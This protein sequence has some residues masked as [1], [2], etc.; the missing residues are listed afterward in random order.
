MSSTNFKNIVNQIQNF[1][2]NQ[3]F[4]SEGYKMYSPIKPK[5]EIEIILS[6]IDRLYNS[7]LPYYAED[8]LWSPFNDFLQ[9]LQ[10]FN[11]LQNQPDLVYNHKTQLEYIKSTFEAL[12]KE[13][14][15]ILDVSELTVPGNHQNDLANTIS[16]ISTRTNSLEKQFKKLAESS[17]KQ[18]E[19][20]ALKVKE[21]K[22]ELELALETFKTRYGEIMPKMELITQIDFY[23]STAKT[24]K[25]QSKTTLNW[26]ISSSIILLLVNFFGFL[27]IDKWMPVQ[28]SYSAIEFCKECTI[29]E[30]DYRFI[31]IVS[32]KA[33]TFTIS[34]IFLTFLIKK[35][36]AE[37]HTEITNIHK[38]NSFYSILAFQEKLSNE[39]NKEILGL[40]A[41]SIFKKKAKQVLNKTKMNLH[42]IYK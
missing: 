30:L 42:R 40:G 38:S 2:Y 5:K 36:R 13:F 35:Y 7:S 27:F 1:N 26:L 34:L 19:D 23:N 12:I 16:S 15:N 32:L 6:Y 24:L 37:K 22:E 17:T 28:D 31:S 21:I 10:G 39:L 41:Y 33:F 18:I 8:R 20:D 11:F 3:L 25:E 4:N 9:W 29:R 14:N